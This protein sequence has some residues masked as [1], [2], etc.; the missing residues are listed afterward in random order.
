MTGSEA[1][2]RIDD[3]DIVA[4]NYKHSRS[5][6]GYDAMCVKLS[7]VEWATSGIQRYPGSIEPE[8]RICD[9]CSMQDP[10]CRFRRASS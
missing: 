4:Q 6:T 10:I 9:Q 1:R 7:Y 8:H 2:M 5:R 3:K